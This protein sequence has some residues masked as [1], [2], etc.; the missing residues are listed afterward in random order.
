MWWTKTHSYLPGT[1]S[2]HLVCCGEQ[3][4]L[5]EQSKSDKELD[6]DPAK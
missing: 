5:D 6:S 4:P 2:E 3:S 1:Y